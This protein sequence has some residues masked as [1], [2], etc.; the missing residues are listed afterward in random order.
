M[1]YAAC[2]ALIFVLVPAVPH[3]AK[4]DRLAH[5]FPAQQKWADVMENHDSP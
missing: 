3:A 2:A 4:T 5:L 1:L